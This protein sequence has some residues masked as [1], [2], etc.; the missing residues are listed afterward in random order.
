MGAGRD[1]DYTVMG[2]AVNLAARLQHA[3]GAGEILVGEATY[4]ATAPV[5]E[6]RS[7]G[8][9][10]VRGKREPVSTW[11]VV[12]VKARRGSLRGLRGL[13]A[14]MVGRDG[15]FTT[16]KTLFR[17]VAQERQLQQVLVLGAAGV[18]KSRLLWEL[19]KYLDGLPQQVYFRKGRCLPYG[20][21]VGFRALAEIIKTQCGIL[22]DDPRPVAETKLRDTVQQVFS[23]FVST[24][25]SLR[26][27]LERQGGSHAPGPG[28]SRLD[29]RCGGDHPL[30]RRR[31]GPAPRRRRHGD[32]PGNGQRRAIL[33]AAALLRPA[34]G[35]PADWCWP[36]RISIGPTAC[37][38]NS[39]STARKSSGPPADPDPRLAR[40]EMAESGSGAAWVAQ[41]ARSDR[42]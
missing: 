29:R 10:Q 5:I 39:S 40:P 7:R 33:G 14:R 11:E 2:D 38:S 31:A 32:R 36:S 16:L 30:A 15:E 18:G 35:Q 34:G 13:E 22:D 26:D 23:D 28:R 25:G 20:P 6:Y 19:E 41:H 8:T 42:T 21:G 27:L 3:A 24:T 17:R 37:C 9:I 1:Q 12:R 4:R